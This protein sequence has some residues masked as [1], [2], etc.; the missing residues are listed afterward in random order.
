M[1]VA[2][3]LAIDPYY[4]AILLE[5]CHLFPLRDT[6][7]AATTTDVTVQYKCCELPSCYQTS[8]HFD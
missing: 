1:M 5:I 4:P 7:K 6:L 3:K 2:T 8:M